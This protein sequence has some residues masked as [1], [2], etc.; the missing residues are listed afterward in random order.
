MGTSL[1]VP[2]SLGTYSS[3]TPQRVGLAGRH[4]ELNAS[5]AVALAAAWEADRAA[6]Q[7][8]HIAAQ[9]RVD[10][11]QKGVLPEA[12]AKGL[13]STTWPGRSQVH[14]NCCLHAFVSC[15]LVVGI[16]NQKGSKLAGIKQADTQPMVMWCYALSS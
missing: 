2:P 15:P 3:S 12:Y 16:C 5:L 10:S 6:T 14:H 4:Q 7:T 8:G 13:E 11:I 1:T 9:E